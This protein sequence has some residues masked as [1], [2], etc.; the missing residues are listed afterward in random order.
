MSNPITGMDDNF[1]FAF[2]S[3]FN[4]DGLQALQESNETTETVIEFTYAMPLV[5][6]LLLQPDIQ[7][8][9]NPSTRPELNNSL[10]FA[11]LAQLSF[12]Y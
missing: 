7:Y 6:W 4:G 10:A 8:V 3:G 11:L 9:I 5:S 1:G 2:S 12:S